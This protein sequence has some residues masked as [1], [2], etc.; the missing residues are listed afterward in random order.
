MKGRKPPREEQQNK[1]KFGDILK[2]NFKVLS[3][4]FKF[5][6]VY[7]VITFI[8]IAIS[9]FEALV[10]VDIIKDAIE[11]V[12]SG[13]DLDLLFKSLIIHMVI[14]LVCYILI[15]FYERYVRTKYMQIYRKRIQEYL[16]RKVKSV[17]MESYDDPEFFDKFTRGLNDAAMRGIRVFETFSNF[18]ASIVA[19]IALGTYVVVGDPWLIIIII[20]S[21]IVNL[22]VV[23]RINKI[24][25][26][27]WHDAHKDRRYYWYVNRIFYGQAY[28]A[29]IKTTP[30]RKL[31]VNKYKEKCDNIEKIY[32]KANKSV[33]IPSFI[34]T[35][36]EYF[37][38]QAGSYLYLGYR[39]FIES[40]SIAQFTTMANATFKF[41][42][43]FLRAINVYTDLRDSSLYN[44]DFVWILNY[45][46]KVER[47]DGLK[48]DEF[49]ELDVQNISFSYPKNEYNTIE[50]L[51]MTI[52]KG[53]KI[54][55]VGDNGGGKT[56]LTKLLLRFYEP[57][58]G[59]ILYNGININEY[60]GKSLRDNYSI[61]F[62]DFQIYAVSIA[63]NVLLRRCE[64]EEDE[65]IVWDALEKV[66]LSDY[67]KSL[68]KGINTQVT[69]EFNEKGVSF[70]GG[71]RQRLAIARV[72][73][74]NAD[75][76]ILDEP[77]AAL[78]PLAEERINKLIIKNA[79]NKTIIIIAHR[80]STVVDMDKI[81]LIRK[82]SIRESGSHDEL[83]KL[84]GIYNE[85]FT[86]QK[87]L[88]QKEE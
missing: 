65:R 19:A 48:V 60:D 31:L 18:L 78:D 68:D 62:Q 57:K 74:S 5:C 64:S 72:F 87:K 41:S 28:A 44:Q 47:K 6:P 81:Y 20:V 71:E 49:K 2:I 3:F 43:N 50:N 4:V 55:I 10:E 54:A 39:L 16:Y 42:R 58:E 14:I 82:G 85:M 9:T 61:I 37:I 12:T 22:L 29:E 36:S 77:T 63:E 34:R 83:I 75:I 21:A 52:K 7:I 53:D 15:A 70:S 17:D 25:H 23:N 88:Y 32:D 80:L 8:Y 11:I 45:K 69:K 26:G 59:Q 46:P 76:Y 38:E 33:I 24:W 86:T 1:I 56:T 40:I 66:G 79:T 51:S 27:V 84:N 73:A 30:I 35:I 67:V 13:N